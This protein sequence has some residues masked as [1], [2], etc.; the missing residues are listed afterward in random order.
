TP[1][2]FFQ[3]GHPFSPAPSQQQTLHILSQLAPAN[4]REVIAWIALCVIGGFAEELIFRGYLQRQFT[5]WSRGATA[6]GVLFS[7]LLFG[8]A[9]GYQGARNMILLSVFGAL[10]SLLA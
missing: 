6:A 3:P 10:F 8:A 1:P 5:A 7:A 9:H 4:G 2:P